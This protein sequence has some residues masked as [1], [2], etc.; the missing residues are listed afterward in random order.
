MLFGVL[1]RVVDDAVPLLSMGV[2]PGASLRMSVLR[3]EV[4]VVGFNLSAGLA[5][6]RDMPVDE[7]GACPALEPLFAS[8]FASATGLSWPPEEVEVTPALQFQVLDGPIGAPDATIS[9]D[10]AG[11]LTLAE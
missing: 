5:D 9:I 4:R 2:K 10:M 6:V 7:Y 3:A 1:V 8:V 11:V